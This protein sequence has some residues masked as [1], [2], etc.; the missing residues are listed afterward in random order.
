MGWSDVVAAS[1][2]TFDLDVEVQAAPWVPATHFTVYENGR[3]LALVSDGAGGYDTATPVAGASLVAPLANAGVVRYHGTI[4]LHPTRDSYYVVVANG[5]SLAPVAHGS[6]YG[7]T[8]PVY[9]DV[10]GGAWMPPG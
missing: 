1:G 4:H 10:G 7:Y 5:D 2:T 8:N 3:P 9:V 6:A